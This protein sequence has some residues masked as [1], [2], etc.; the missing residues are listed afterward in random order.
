MATLQELRN[1][2]RTQLELDPEDLPN[3]QIDW[4]LR[5]AFQRT[6]QTEQLWPFYAQTWTVESD[7]DG[8]IDVPAELAAIMSLV[9]VSTG[10]RLIFISQELGEQ[11]FYGDS[12]GGI[13]QFFSLWG[14]RLFLWSRPTAARTYSLRG[15]RRSTDWIGNGEDPTV[16]V[17]ADD[18]LHLPLVHYAASMYKAFEE[19]E[20]MEQVYLARWN[21][22]VERARR[23][24]MRPQH[25]RPLVFNGGLRIMPRR[26][27]VQFNWPV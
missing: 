17:D 9:D 3:E 14:P 26:A 20:V 25:S 6:I 2:V 4:Y 22:G 24:I 21:D 23:D 7:G 27:S 12:A 16:V 13:P 5:E 8:G 10:S 18:R 19:D 15:F 1:L 11:S